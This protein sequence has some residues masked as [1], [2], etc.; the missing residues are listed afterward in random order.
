MAA[1]VQGGAERA[2]LREPSPRS[3]L[4]R[5][6]RHGERLAE[7][8]ILAVACASVLS[9]LLILVFVGKE[10]LPVLTSDAIHAEVTPGALFLPRPG[11]GFVWQPVS[12]EPKYN[13]V[14]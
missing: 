10:A 12:L 8:L 1:T 9:V 6:V 7:G 3:S 4:R 14:P 13:I 2:T 5:R 11:L